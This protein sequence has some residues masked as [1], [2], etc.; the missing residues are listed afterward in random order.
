MNPK[1]MQQAMKQLGIKQEDLDASEV[2]IRLSDREIV[3]KNPSVQKIKMQG[4]ESFQISGNSE[5]RALNSGEEEEVI[6]ITEEDIETVMAQ[7][8]C[9]KEKAEE[10]LVEAEGDLAMAVLLLSEK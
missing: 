1:Q 5:E 7:A 6:E 3:I 8:N 2:I 4:Q 9:S 10:A